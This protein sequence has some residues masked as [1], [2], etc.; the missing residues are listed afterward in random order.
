MNGVLARQVEL[1]KGEVGLDGGMWFGEQGAG[2]VRLNFACPR[3]LLKKD[4]IE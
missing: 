3:E 2:H 4:W 1:A